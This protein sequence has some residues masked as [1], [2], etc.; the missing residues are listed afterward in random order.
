MSAAVRK[1]E[2]LAV[3][4]RNTLLDALPGR[5]LSRVLAA[6]EEVQLSL[7]QSVYEPNVPVRH[8]YFPISGVVSL[9][10]ELANGRFVEI[11]TVGSEGVVGLPVFFGVRTVPGRAFSQIAGTAVRMSAGAFREL[12]HAEQALQDVLHLYAQALFNQVSWSVACL[13]Q[14]A[15]KRRC[16]RWLLMMHDRVDSDTFPLTQEFLGQM[17]SVRR[18]A[19][20]EAASELQALGIIR[21]TRGVITVDDR[22]K[23]EAQS[24]ECYG[25]VRDD[26]ER[27]LGRPITGS[28]T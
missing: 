20:S 4:P 23:L 16:A 11:A 13:R 1:G 7:K 18:A 8:V 22:E 24:C 21:Y 3:R 10:N 6:S 26:Y 14:H 9:V 19:V 27:L 2:V 25:V 12:A 15:V 5:V 28:P 17:L